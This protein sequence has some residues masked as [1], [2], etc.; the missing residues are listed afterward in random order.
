M[1]E[2]WVQQCRICS[3]QTTVLAV[4]EL[5]VAYCA[6]LILMTTNNFYRNLLSYLYKGQEQLSAITR[7]V[8]RNIF[9]QLLLKHCKK[10]KKGIW[11]LMY[12]CFL[13]LLRASIT[14]SLCKPSWFP[15]ALH[16]CE[17]RPFQIDSP[18]QCPD[19]AKT[20]HCHMNTVI[21]GYTT[22]QN[23]GVSK[24][25]VLCCFEINVCFYSAKMN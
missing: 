24:T 13:C 19:P 7:C 22:V 23:S 14:H 20:T 21:C 4:K 25:F 6:K 12:A 16:Y 18:H 3:L 9:L 1:N 2:V 15:W 11:I 8:S 10:K 5:P 17:S